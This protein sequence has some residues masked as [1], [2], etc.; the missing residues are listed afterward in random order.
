MPVALTES[1]T[2]ANNA[3]VALRLRE[4]ADLL[5][6]QL[7]NPFRVRAYRN[8]AR[9]VEELPEPVLDLPEGG[10]KSL[11]ELPGIGEDLA[12]KIREIAASGS[13]RLLSQL[14]RKVPKGLPELT[15]LRG[16]GPRRA[17]VLRKR[18]GIRSLAGLERA[19]RS[20]RV[21]KVR[22][23]GEK[24]E[25]KLLHELGLHQTG[26]G[27]TLRATAAQYAE[28]IAEYLRSRLAWTRWRSREASGA[29]L[30]PSATWTSWL[31]A[32]RS[33]R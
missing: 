22:G 32:G 2:G 8:A 14:R 33:R 12:A 25:A 13:L 9:T 3:E 4:I 19:L 26:D 30:R 7:A 18:L 28:P 29:G 23:F 5:E 24:S 1:A 27:R 21:R 20:R 15:R 10:V 6:L 11:Q 31:P 16:L 17:R